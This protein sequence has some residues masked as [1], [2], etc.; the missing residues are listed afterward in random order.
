MVLSVYRCSLLYSVPLEFSN[1]W[2]QCKAHKLLIQEP[3]CCVL[4][5]AC[6]V[7]KGDMLVQAAN[8]TKERLA[9]FD[10]PIKSE[11]AF[12]P[13]QRDGLLADLSNYLQTLKVS[14]F[15]SSSPA[16]GPLSKVACFLALHANRLH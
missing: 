1:S 3:V 15:S 9:S 16:R 10:R 13:D 7:A 4:P 8:I 2:L 5:I 11:P 14:C 6:C 12:K